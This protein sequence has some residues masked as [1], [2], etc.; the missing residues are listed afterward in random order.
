MEL[1]S[2]LKTLTLLEGVDLKSIKAAIETD[3]DPR[4][5]YSVLSK[6]AKDNRLPGLFDP[7]TG[8]YVNA[9]GQPEK[10]VSDEVVQYLGKLCLVPEIA[11]TNI[12]GEPKAEKVKDDAVLQ[13]FKCNTDNEIDEKIK[14][15]D[16]L[17]KLT[18]MLTRANESK[19]SLADALY[20]SFF[21]I[22]EAV[23]TTQSLD[24]VITEMLDIIDQLNEVKRWYPIKDKEIDSAIARAQA[25][26]QAARKRGQIRERPLNV[27]NLTPPPSP[28][29]PVTTPPVVDSPPRPNL[30][31]GAIPGK[32]SPHPKPYIWDEKLDAW[33]PGPPIIPDPTPAPEPAPP[34][35]EPRPPVPE[36][37]PRPRPTPN[38]KPKVETPEEARKR[39][40]EIDD[41]IKRYPKPIKGMVSTQ[42]DSN[43]NSIKWQDIYKINKG[44]IGNNPNLIKPGQVLTIPGKEPYEVK[45][46]DTLSKIAV[47]Q[48]L[49]ESRINSDDQ[50]LALI[51]GVTY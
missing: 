21:D 27:D 20:E 34:K 47:Q 28:K 11:K 12:S 39:Q 3:P 24:G 45:P 49:K 17:I 9:N 16:E 5:R 32:D 6:I 2:L 13:S 35:P 26:I 41:L 40:K 30:P 36:P 33:I 1:T 46:G 23:A 31:P 50:T 51:K 38:N 19:K 4:S 10:N 48:S 29:P 37:R 8:V 22:N 42:P 43:S 7:T 14:K 44:I 18:I 25:A 15:L